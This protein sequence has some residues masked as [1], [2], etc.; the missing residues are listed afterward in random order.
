MKTEQTKQ[1]QN[2]EFI[3]HNVPMHEKSLLRIHVVAVISR[4]KLYHLI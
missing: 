2:F 3:F 4:I 1:E